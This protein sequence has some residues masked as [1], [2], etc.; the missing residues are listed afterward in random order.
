VLR[1]ER[2]EILY[3]YSSDRKMHLVHEDSLEYLW[4]GKF[5]D[6]LEAKQ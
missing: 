6:M 5:W 4:P 3:V 2:N 1:E